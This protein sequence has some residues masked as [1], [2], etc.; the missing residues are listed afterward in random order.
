M[1]TSARAVEASMWAVGD[2]YT[3]GWVLDAPGVPRLG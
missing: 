3:A 1:V 2:G